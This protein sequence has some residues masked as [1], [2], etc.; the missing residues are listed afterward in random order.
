MQLSIVFIIVTLFWVALIVY[1]LWMDNRRNQLLVLRAK[2]LY[3]SPL[4]AAMWPLLKQCKA[5]T[6]ERFHMDSNG[7]IVSFMQPAG[8]MARYAN[9]GSVSFSVKKEGLDK[10]TAQ[11]QEALIVLLEQALPKLAD[12]SRYALKINRITLLN[13]KRDVVYDYV[14]RNDYKNML[15]RAPYYDDTLRKEAMVRNGWI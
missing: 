4:F 15:A 3:A 14:I 5:R 11:Q 2:K 9:I 6:I 10:L 13:G 12:Q 7:F 8:E 1:L